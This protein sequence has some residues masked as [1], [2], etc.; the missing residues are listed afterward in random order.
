MNTRRPIAILGGQRIPFARQ[1][2][3]YTHASNLEMLT[4][5][6]DA[7]VKRFNLQSQRLGEVAAGAVLKHTRDFN[8][9]REAVLASQLAPQTPAYDV[10]QA[11]AT[12]IETAIL[13]GNKIGMGQIEVG[14]A[15]GVDSSSD[16]PV[17][18]SESYRQLVLALNRAKTGSDR[19]RILA[20]F[21]LS[22][23]RP[24][25]PNVNERRT[26]LSMGEHCELMVKQWGVT[27]EAQ[28][29]LA[30]ASHRN[31]IAAYEEGFYSDLV[32]PFQGL[33]R[34]N[35]LRADT[36]MEKLAR[37]K[38]AYDKSSG[39]GTL[40]AGNSTPLTDGAAAILLASA[41]W[42]NLHGIRPQAWLV[43]AETAAVDY[44]GP[45]AEG[46]LMAPAYGV[47]RLLK[48]NGL[49]LQDFDYYEIHEAFAGQ[50]LCTMK[51]WEDPDYCRERLGLTHALGSIDRSKLN[52]RGGSVGL[53]HP[54]AATGARILGS[55]AKQLMLHRS[56]TGK[57]ARA[58]VSVCAAGGLGATAIVE[59]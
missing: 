22:M 35:N 59:A 54:F 43:D 7:V 14:I 33:Q 38:P 52:V 6:I 19:L 41:E 13:V 50:V 47:P 42:A 58:L 10:Q 26:G 44:A 36:S 55:V 51:A 29:E 30:L 1:T 31:G 28:D 27:R 18:L 8:L 53:G 57:P 40:T 5:T 34:D 46:L 49:S 39:H 15:G 16:A 9:T 37:L 2:T 20:G 24:S 11:C 17:A 23:F 56:R 45:H 25:V 32:V 48:R 21:R 4:A 12:S 3:A